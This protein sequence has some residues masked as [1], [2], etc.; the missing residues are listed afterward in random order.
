MSKVLAFTLTWL[1][2]ISA[3]AAAVG[4]GGNMPWDAPLTALQTDLTGTTATAISLIGIVAVFGVLIFGGELNHFFRTLCYIILLVSVLVAGQNILSDLN[5]TGAT[6]DN[7]VGYDVYGF[8]SG[9]LV[10]SLIW[11]FGLWL[12]RRWRIRQRQSEAAIAQ[13]FDKAGS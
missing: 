5:I 7:H 1:L 2:P 8:I 10:T 11:A 3:F 4:G 12:H 6:V 13:V 9:V